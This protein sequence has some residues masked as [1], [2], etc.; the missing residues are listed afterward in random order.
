[1][2]P[3]FPP[4]LS[5]GPPRHPKTPPPRR[6]KP[7]PPPWTGGNLKKGREKKV[8]C[9]FLKGPGF[10][11]TFPPPKKSPPPPPPPPPPFPPPPPPPPPV[12]LIGALQPCSQA[13]CC[14]G[15]DGFQRSRNHHV[16]DPPYPFPCLHTASDAYYLV[17][18]TSVPMAHHSAHGMVGMA[19]DSWSPRM[20][21]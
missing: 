10:K 1:M 19:P 18:N 8:F 4:S 14:E 5:G 2:P 15:W 17:P 20:P 9:F 7:A 21:M 13:V 12:C 11:K 16:L 3:L 6:K